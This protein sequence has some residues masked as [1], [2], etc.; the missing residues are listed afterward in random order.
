MWKKIAQLWK[1]STGSAAAAT[2]FFHLW[3]PPTVHWLEHMCLGFAQ[4]WLLVIVVCKHLFF[5]KLI[6]DGY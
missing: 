2:T 6:R 1:I 3:S 4:R 5:A